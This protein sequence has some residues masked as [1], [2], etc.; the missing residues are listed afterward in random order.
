V[1]DPPRSGLDDTVIRAI[2]TQMPEKIIYISCAP[3]TLSRDLEKLCAA[4]FRIK[5]AGLLDMF[6]G[7]AHFE[8]LTVL[9]RP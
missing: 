8:T 6:P 3:D 9:T 7:T 4:G 1:V 2:I 5:S